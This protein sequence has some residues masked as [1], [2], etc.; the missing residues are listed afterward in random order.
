MGEVD[1]GPDTD[2]SLVERVARSLAL[3]EG[4]RMIAPGQSKASREFTWEMDGGHTSKYIEQHWREHIHAATFA[5]AA[6]REPGAS[7]LEAGGI[8]MAKAIGTDPWDCLSPEQDAVFFD[9]TTDLTDAAHELLAP[10]AADIF[11]GMIDAA[12]SEPSSGERSP[13]YEHT[14]YGG[15]VDEA[16]ALRIGE[17]PKTDQS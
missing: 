5:I 15:Y 1:E 17:I 3:V 12:L 2:V 10:L 6:M 11:R 4:S 16:G 9:E 14:A 7:V 8:E 13:D